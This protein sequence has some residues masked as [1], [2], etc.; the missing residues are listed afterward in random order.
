MGTIIEKNEQIPV[1][2]AYVI[3]FNASDSS[4]VT[5][6][7]TNEDG[8]FQLTEIRPGNYYLKF[9]FM[10]YQLTKM[11]DIQ[12]NRNNRDINLGVITLDK[13]ILDTE[14]IDVVAEKPSI[15]YKIDKKIINVDQMQTNISGTAVDIL[16]NVPSVTV[17]I[18]GN[19]SLRGSESFVVLIDNKPSILEP[20]EILQ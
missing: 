13:I 10:G 11:S 19:V 20:N 17:D 7:V 9:Q 4:Q 15:S 1:E 5:G 18:E 14:S 2:Y 8:H 12:I 6:S 3:L 16:E